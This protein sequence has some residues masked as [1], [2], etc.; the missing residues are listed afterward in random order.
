MHAPDVEVVAV[1]ARTPVGLNAESSSAAV[2]AGIVRL[3]EYPWIDPSG[4]P[5]VVAADAQLDPK[6]EGR[7][8][9]L[10]LIEHV[11]AEVDTKL[12]PPARTSSALRVL[13]ALP[14][15]RPGFTDRDAIWISEMVR[16]RFRPPRSKVNVELAEGRGHAAVIGAVETAMCSGDRESIFL[17]VGA[18]SH[19]HPD[20]FTWLEGERRFAQ[21]DVRNG[22]A[23]GEGAGCLAIAAEEL[24]R[25]LH[26][27]SL[28]VIRGARTARETLLRGSE[29]GSF[30]AAMTQALQQLQLADQSIDDIYLDLNGERYRSEEWGFVALRSPRLWK[31]LNYIAPA[32]SWGDVGAAFAA[33][34]GVLAVRSF[35]RRYASGPRALILAASDGGLRGAM[36]LE[37]SG[38]TRRGVTTN[39]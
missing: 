2:R 8:R 19:H 9:L 4:A 27:P 23:P 24:I 16:S 28:A 14:E 35:A 11:L 13:L 1:G 33:L 10:P 15:A 17:I 22:F 37:D 3:K 5:V 34:A 25:R 6:I 39:G 20:T 29:T 32:D 26:I 12:G 36:V 7:D 18:D 30:G 21:P 31:S 38:S